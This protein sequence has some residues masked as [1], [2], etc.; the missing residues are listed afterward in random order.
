VPDEEQVPYDDPGLR[1]AFRRG[2]RACL[3][4]KPRPEEQLFGAGKRGEAWIEGYEAAG[5]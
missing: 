2:W 1:E 4:G 3:R 5:C